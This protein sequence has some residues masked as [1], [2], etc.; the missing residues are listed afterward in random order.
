M[1]ESLRERS[2]KIKRTYKKEGD[3]EEGG[4]PKGKKDKPKGGVPNGRA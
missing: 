3:L 2:A 1:E 4:G